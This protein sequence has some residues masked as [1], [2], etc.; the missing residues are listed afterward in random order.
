[1]MY[2]LVYDTFRNWIECLFNTEA[3]GVLAVLHASSSQHTG[4]SLVA[5][6]FQDI[7]GHFC[8]SVVCHAFSLLAW[9][10]PR[11]KRSAYPCALITKFETLLV[12]K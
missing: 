10:N 4:Q 2:I 5:V 9:F 6:P 7:S 1:M 11:M 3:H 12:S 8:S